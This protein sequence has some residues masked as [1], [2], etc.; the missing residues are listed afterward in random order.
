MQGPHGFN[1]GLLKC[2]NDCTRHSVCSETEE[3]DEEITDNETKPEIPDEVSNDSD[4]PKPTERSHLTQLND[5]NETPDD[6]VS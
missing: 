2:K 5:S 3:P 1:S 4:N 6:E